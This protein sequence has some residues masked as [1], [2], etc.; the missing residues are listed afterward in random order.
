MKTGVFI[1][2]GFILV[3]SSSVSA[4]PTKEELVARPRLMKDALEPV[5]KAVDAEVVRND[6]KI[7]SGRNTAMFGFNT[8]EVLV[9]L[10][11]IDNSAYAIVTFGEPRLVDNK[12]VAVSFEL[13][14]GGYNDDTFSNEIRLAQKEG[15]GLVT[16]ARV[17]G[18]GRIKYPLEVKTRIVKKDTADAKGPDITLDGP[19]VTYIDHNI[20]DMIFLSTRLGPVRAYDVKGRR[21][22]EHSYNSTSTQGDVTRRTLAFWGDIAEI[23][24]DTVTRWIDIEFTYDL[25]P[26][27]PL[28][29]DYAGKSMSRPPNLTET[30]GGIVQKK[31]TKIV[32]AAKS[33][34]KKS[35]SET[36]STD[37]RSKD[38]GDT[39]VVFK[40]TE[41]KSPVKKDCAKG[42]F[43]VDGKKVLLN[44]AYVEMREDPFDK[45]R[46]ALWVYLTDHPV[47]LGD[48]HEQI[49]DLSYEGKLQFI[50][51][52]INQ[53]KHIIGMVLETP[54][55]KMGYISSAGG[56]TFEDKKFGP[57][58][59]EGLAFT[60]S[61]EFQNQKYSYR[62]EFRATLIE[63]PVDK[64]LKSTEASTKASKKKQSPPEQ[65]EFS[66]DVVDRFFLSIMEGDMET[67]KGFLD[68]G[69][70]P[71]VNRPRF[72]HSPVFAAVMGNRDDIALMFIK[73]GGD[74]NFKDENGSTP[75]MWAAENCK[76]V[77]LVKAL[78]NAGADVNARAKGGATPLMMAEVR[79]C[80]EIVK[81]LKKA[82][83]K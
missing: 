11:R 47:P 17:M 31:L 66:D 27:K 60:D 44:H 73:A 4:Q 83:A 56:H 41:D 54:L 23:Q 21:L 8:P 61:R 15:E 26:I 74:V 46:K 59:I 9:Y 72:G 19:F 57:S 30:P 49:M 51:L 79:Q 35:E 53:S 77:P 76:S 34:Y 13:E 16:F 14:G 33:D 80:K 32:E 67:V 25:P 5:F 81:I 65:M 2:I 39:P 82:G 28:S 36:V 18:S 55:L 52:N 71:N 43:E 24:I 62:V 63:A 22:E 1:A 20:S 70:P 64:G 7:V 68:A 29:E 10:P 45:T 50:E 6:S 40:P 42:Y 3:L 48:W 37:V 12:G 78:V 75:L 58:V 38:G 69:M